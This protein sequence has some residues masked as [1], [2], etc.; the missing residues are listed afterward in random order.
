MYT[1]TQAELDRYERMQVEAG[2]PIPSRFKHLQF[3]TRAADERRLSG[4]GYASRTDPKR[5]AIRCEQYAVR[6]LPGLT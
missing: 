5:R 4:V 2:G 1:L 6:T 3:S